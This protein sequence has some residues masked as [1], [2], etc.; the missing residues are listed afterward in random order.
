MQVSKVMR[1]L[2]LP[3]LVDQRSDK[4]ISKVLRDFPSKKKHI[5][6]W[7]TV[8]QVMT[9]Y[10]QFLHAVLCLVIER[11]CRLHFRGTRRIKPGSDRTHLHWP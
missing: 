3:V 4:V 9:Y 8:D 5:L 7:C 11:H 1:Q 10:L 6:G 2:A